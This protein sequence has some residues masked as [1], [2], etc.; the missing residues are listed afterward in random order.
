MWMLPVAAAVVAAGAFIYVVDP[1]RAW[2]MPSCLFHQLTGLYCPGCGTGRA[3]H[4][5]AHGNLAAAWRL[6]PLMVLAIP[7]LI[8]LI[9]KSSMPA[10]PNAK[11]SSL[12]RWLPWV[13][14]G[15]IIAF[16]VVRNIPAYPFTLLAPH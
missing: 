8:Y 7:L 1:G 9:A 5:L 16:W 11:Q 2:W 14:V 13:V 15:T 3:L 4:Q 10:R 12:P 6:N